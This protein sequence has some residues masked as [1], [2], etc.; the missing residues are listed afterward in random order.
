MIEMKRKVRIACVQ[1]DVVYGDI[2]GTIAKVTQWVEKAAEE[3]ADVALF[4]ELVLSAGYA[5][6]ERYKSVAETIPGPSTEIIA[7]LAREKKLNIIIGIAE[8]TKSGVLHDSAVFFDRRGQNLGIYRK[9]H[10]YPPTESI[11]ERGNELPIIHTDFGPV[12][13]LICYDL[14]FPET[15]RILALQG[16]EIIFHLVADWPEGVPGLPERI[17]DISF[18]SR[19]LENR[20]VLAVSNRVG[21]DP[22]LKSH[23][24]GLSRIIGTQ[25]EIIASADQGEKMILAEIDLE[26]AKRE[27]ETYNYF[28]NRRPELYGILEQRARHGPR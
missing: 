10:T 25:G 7:K 11:F 1:M 9:S 18:R 27:R 3:H 15:A 23:F 6:G 24:Y 5:L 8:K 4:P 14:E 16:A 13:L 22:D 12:G 26:E 21:D 28:P 17:F 20:I 2:S 19:A